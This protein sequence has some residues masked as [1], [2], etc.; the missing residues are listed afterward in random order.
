MVKF[1]VVTTIMHASQ[2]D[3]ILVKCSKKQPTQ[4]VLTLLMVQEL[5][6][7]CSFIKMHT[8]LNVIE[9]P[10]AQST[11][12]K[13][14]VLLYQASQLHVSRFHREAHAFIQPYK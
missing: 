10:W 7:K 9:V 1:R 13:V 6:V 8:G 11:C 12:T 3:V 4:P 2:N 5:A 14:P